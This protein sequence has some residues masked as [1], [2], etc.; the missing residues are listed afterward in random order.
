MGSINPLER[1]CPRPEEQPLPALG[2]TK[3]GSASAGPGISLTGYLAC[4]WY[5]R[6]LKTSHL[7]VGD[8]LVAGNAGGIT[9]E[10]YG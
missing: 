9:N 3:P 1:Y 2:K 7:N 6:S 5:C 10:Q 4:E 8:R